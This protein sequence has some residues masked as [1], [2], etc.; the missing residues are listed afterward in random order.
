MSGERLLDA[1]G[2][3][4]GELRG[5]FFCALVPKI[6]APIDAVEYLLASPIPLHAAEVPMPASYTLAPAS[7]EYAPS[8][9]GYVSRVPPGD[10]IDLLETQIEDTLRLLDGLSEE[11]A[12]FRYAPDKWSVKQIVGHLIDAERVFVFRAL[13]FSRNEPKPLPGYD[14]DEY[15]QAANFDHRPWRDLLDEFRAVRRAT[16]H[17][18][19]GLDEAMMERTGVAND[20]TFTVRALAYILA[21]HERHH[22]YVLRERYLERKT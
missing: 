12:G 20:V 3:K 1:T 22:V 8:Y 21:G 13:S 10:I 2:L 11:D 17:F 6:D 15:A 14:Q 4:D 5:A 19:R 18:F 9:T 16:V 7:S